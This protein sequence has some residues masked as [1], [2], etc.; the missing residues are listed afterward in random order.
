MITSGAQPSGL[1]GEAGYTH[2]FGVVAATS[3]L[4]ALVAVFIPVVRAATH[5]VPG[6]QAEAE[7][8]DHVPASVEA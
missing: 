5:V 1:P 6:P 7:A 8:A 3:A 2:G 4:A